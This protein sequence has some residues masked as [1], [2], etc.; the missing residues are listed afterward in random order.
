VVKGN[1]APPDRGIAP[2]IDEKMR[3][4]EFFA[5]LPPAVIDFI[6]RDCGVADA[7]HRVDAL[8]GYSL[9]YGLPINHWNVRYP[10]LADDRG[11]PDGNAQL[12]ATPPTSN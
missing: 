4:R 5:R 9:K 11:T 7:D 3:L 1:E 8:V 2:M 6:A 10:E 12:A